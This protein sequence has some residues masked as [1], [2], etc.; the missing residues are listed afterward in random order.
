MWHLPASLIA[1]NNDAAG[2][3]A[4]D[5]HVREQLVIRSCS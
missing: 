5:P 4:V 2:R 3:Q 1:T